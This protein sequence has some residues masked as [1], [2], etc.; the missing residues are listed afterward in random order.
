[1][2]KTSLRERVN[3]LRRRLAPKPRKPWVTWLW[4]ALLLLAATL[5][6]LCLCLLIGTQNYSFSRFCAYFRRP[7]VFVMNV[8]PMVLL[9]LILYA[10]TNRAWIAWLSTALFFLLFFY[11][12]YFKVALRGEP[13]VA[14]DLLVA[15]E[16]IG[17]LKEYTLHIPL[18]LW[19]SLLL[20]AVG[21]LVLMRYAR[22]RVPKKRWYIRVL[23]PVLCVAFGAY[24]WSAWYTDRTLYDSTRLKLQFAFSAFRD[25]EVSAS[26][27][28]VW[29]FLR[30]VDEALPAAP[31]DYD[32][33]EI[34]A[35]LADSPDTAIPADKK[36]NV[37]ATMLESYCDLSVFDGVQFT[38]DPYAELHA[39]QAESYHG[40]L[41]A[42]SI[43]GGTVNAE[44]AF[45]TGF[46]YRQ[47]SYRR[48]TQS[49]VRY[50]SDNGYVTTGSHPGVGTFYSRDSINDCLGFDDYLFYEEHYGEVAAA[51]T[52]YDGTSYADDATF[53]PE[54]RALYEARDTATPYFSFS[55]T[56]Q[57]HSPYD[58]TALRGG[59]YI[60]RDGLSD[61]AYY[62]VNNYLDTVAETGRA[63][64][65][66]VD[67]FRDDEEPVVLVFFGDHKP[68]LGSKNAYYD[69]LGITDDTEKNTRMKLYSTPYLIWANDAAKEVLGKDF[70]GEGETISPCYLMSVLFD[71]CGWEGSSWLQCQRELRATLPVLH[72]H[73][74]F[75]VDG[76]LTSNC[77]ADV[78]AA[79]KRYDCLEYY[80]RQKVPQ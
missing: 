66:Y 59:E 52:R 75:L 79:C 16:G 28:L 1:M 73:V 71:C 36:V 2:E 58:D 40:T 3:G 47:P 6:L 30:S 22:G 42:D 5:G 10:L 37:V 48:D 50:F 23:V 53:F 68:T 20:V 70:C 67:S 9:V 15:G 4:T 77:P 32:E 34:A 24:A 55:V 61:E 80:M 76:V 54:L 69:E 57:G 13:F 72:F 26:G 25:E 44:R 65:A 7:L 60:A 14:D 19:L 27:G 39:L 45:L 31:E 46:T 35:L 78:E 21:T 51:G 41:I 17:I 29:S 64:A 18:S 38:A 8:L 43:G 63:I 12:N 33:A 49:F 11:V 74:Y 56:Y 62:T